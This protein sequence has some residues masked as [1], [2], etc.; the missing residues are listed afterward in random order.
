M[1][2]PP[3]PG[4]PTVPLGRPAAN[5]RLYVL[6]EKLE[7]AP[8]GVP[9][10]AYIA[11]EV[12]V[13][14]CYHARPDLTA[15]RFLPDPFW[16]RGG[17]MYRTGDICRYRNDGVLEH[18]GR[19][20]RQVKVRGMRIELAEI[21]A[22]LC[23]HEAVET[24]V[25]LA[26]DDAAGQRI[27]AFVTPQNGEPI[28]PDELAEHAA[29]FL[30]RYMVPASIVS[31]SGIPTTINGKIDRDALLASWREVD[32]AAMREAVPPSGEGEER[33]KRIFERVLGRE[34]VSV[35][36]SFFD[37]GGHSLLVFK[38]ISACAQELHY[39]PSVPDIFSSPSVREL[40]AK[41]SLPGRVSNA[42][43]TPLNPAPGKPIIVFIHAASGSALPFYEV[44]KR[45]ADDFSIFGLQAPDF[46]QDNHPSTSIK[47]LAA[48][49]IEE[50]DAV[51]GLSPV[52][53]AGWS[54]GGCVGLEMARRW[55]ERGVEV[56]AVLMLDSF[57]P[58]GVLATAA[59]RAEARKAI[60][61]TDF[62]GLEGIAEDASEAATRL[63]HALRANRSAFL[64]YELIW[65]DGDVDYLRAV[66]PFP[67]TP[68]KFPAIYSSPDR[69][70]GSHVRS[71]T[72]HDIAGNHFNL[73]AKENA[74]A[75][76]DTIRGIAEARLSFSIV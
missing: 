34:D 41:M 68:V 30:P 32:T 36:D 54:M 4:A 11:G 72:A 46:D 50:V 76:A 25:A 2:L 47:G 26:V 74:A 58:P 44:A 8:I 53:L 16:F 18:L 38:L 29:R 17:R 13:A 35:T 19:I 31:V 69:G 40:N 55:R 33:L 28:I 49:Y 75:L 66:E 24:C 64:D 61:E 20:G 37:L 60:E 51:R 57:V 39:R 70:W 56:A 42:S 21:E 10:E 48:S 73:F 22:V 6:D 52:I 62:L 27:L 23:E 45:L 3:D 43:L 5:F 7:V 63:G 65:F 14:Q 71:V 12:G 1:I 15:E 59:E 67:K 9:G